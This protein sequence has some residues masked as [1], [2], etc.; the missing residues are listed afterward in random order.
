[1]QVNKV[2]AGVVVYH[3]DS[4]VLTN[5]NTYY[6]GVEKLIVIDNSETRTTFQNDLHKLFPDAIYLHLNRNAGIAAALNIACEIAIE[7]GYKW[8]LTMD[9]DSSFNLDEL[10]EMIARIPLVEI[11]FKKVGIITPYHVLHT[12]DVTKT[13]EQYSV[14]NIV[15]ASGNLL[16]L[17]AYTAIGP[18]EEKLFMDYADY[19]YC[20]RL[21]K[22]KYQIIQDNFVKLKH[23]LGSYAIKK[24]FGVS[25]GVSNHNSVRRYY[26]IRNSLYVSFKYFSFDKLFFLHTVKNTFLLHPFLILSFEK[27]KWAKMKSIRKGILHFLF[28]KYGKT[29]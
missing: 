9:Q 12:E 7:G 3:P 22:N 1:M 8:I 18:F 17:T 21:R 16:N 23:S 10:T 11:L 5:I 27:D 28:H 6:S 13:T 14:K 25:F 4:N 26:M 19:E 15:M 2:A 20:L 24:M 29:L